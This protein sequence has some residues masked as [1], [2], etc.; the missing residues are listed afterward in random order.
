MGGTYSSTPTANLFWSHQNL[1]KLVYPFLSSFFLL[2]HL[3]KYSSQH[4]N[5]ARQLN[6]AQQHSTAQ[7]HN[8]TQHNT[9]Q[10]NTTQHNTTQHNTTQHNTIQYN[11]TQQPPLHSYQLD[12][13]VQS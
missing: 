11:T 5:T 7:Q 2:H 3:Q 1:Q 9:T 6:T 12:I 8:T 13:V 4:S 10:H